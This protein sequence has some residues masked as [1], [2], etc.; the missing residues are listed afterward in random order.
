MSVALQQICELNSLNPQEP[1]NSIFYSRLFPDKGVLEPFQH[2]GKNPLHY[3]HEIIYGPPGCGKSTTFNDL[4]YE[5]KLK[6]G[7]NNVNAILI[8]GASDNRG[9]D[10]SLN[11]MMDHLNNKPVQL[12]FT[13]D[14]TGATLSGPTITRFRRIRHEAQTK[15]EHNYGLIITLVGCHRIWGK[16]GLPLALHENYNLIMKGAP[17]NPWDLSRLYNTIGI[18]AVDVLEQVDREKDNNPEIRAFGIFRVG[19][20]RA[21]IGVLHTNFHL[22]ED[23]SEKLYYETITPN[24]EYSK[25]IK[26]INS[27]WTSQDWAKAKGEGWKQK[28]HL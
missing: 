4:A 18:K 23:G 14:R 28:W 10:L 2:P 1:M 21:E 20:G 5:A 3:K 13:D 6:Y 7:A 27:N 24:T 15:S 22:N 19:T 8:E 16:E 25:P 11:T 12:L 26:T 9:K 17:S